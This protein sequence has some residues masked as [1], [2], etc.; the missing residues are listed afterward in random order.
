[1]DRPDNTRGNVYETRGP[2][3]LGHRC[4]RQSAQSSYCET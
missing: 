1:M 4:K 2:S 3:Y